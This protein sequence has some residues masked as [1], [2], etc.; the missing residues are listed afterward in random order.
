M[1]DITLA[2]DTDNL[3]LTPNQPLA[4]QL[5]RYRLESLKTNVTTAAPIHVFSAWLSES[6]SK[7]AELPIANDVQLRWL[8]EKALTKSQAKHPNLQA[9]H[10]ATQA[11]S[12]WRYLKRFDVPLDMLKSS[13]IGQEAYFS[14]TVECF[15]DLLSQHKLST[16]EHEI[17]RQCAASEAQSSV[18][19]V[20]ERCYLYAF[21]DEP[22]PLLKQW[23]AHC[24]A[25]VEF[26][27]YANTKS[28]SYLWSGAEQSEELLAAAS[29]AN[30]I[31]NNNPQARVGIVHRDL[32]AD[33][34]RSKRLVRSKLDSA[35]YI[36][37]ALKPPASETGAIQSA[38][39]LLQI[40]RHK[41]K[42]A[43]ARLIIHSPL[44]GNENDYRVRADWDKEVCNTQL[45]ELSFA[46]LRECIK[47]KLSD[48]HADISQRLIAFEDIRRRAPKLQTPEQWATTFSQQLDTLGWPRTSNDKNAETTA[49]IRQ[50]WLDLLRDY[51][52]C[53]AVATEL[54]MGDALSLLQQ[55]C[56]RP[57]TDPGAAHV[58]VRLLDTVEAAADYT[59]LWMIGV[60][61]NQWPA[62]PNPNPL[63]PLGL[64]R[65]FGMPG[66]DRS[67][68]TTVARKLLHRLNSAAQ[69]VVF[70]YSEQSDGVALSAS[71]LLPEG[72]QELVL[73]PETAP[74]ATAPTFDFEFIDTLN[75]P[76]L[77][78]HEHQVRSFA[79]LLQQMAASPFDAFATGR[80]HAR[81]LEETKIGLDARDRGN[82]VHYMMEVIWADLKNQ[83]T[84][85]AMDED[86]RAILCAR[87]AE[88]ALRTWRSSKFASMA[89]ISKAHE[90]LEIQRL[91]SLGMRWLEIE[92]DR[93]PFQVEAIEQDLSAELCGLSFKLR[94]DRIDR[95]EDGSVV[96]LDYKTSKQL[97][98]GKW[99]ESPPSEPQLPLYAIS[100][101]DA[102]DAVAFVQLAPTEARLIGLGNA[103]ENGI[104]PS[105]DWAEQIDSW[106]DSLSALAQA[107][108]DGDAQVH[109]TKSSFGRRDPLIPLHRSLERATLLE[110]K[111]T[112]GN[113]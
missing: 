2:L 111:E 39:G 50:L 40:N 108:A 21:L 57:R 90:Q 80:L 100:L 70:S 99:E 91:A 48:S 68:E 28:S 6:V 42:L 45:R 84:L 79:S 56:D 82:L 89:S 4:Q 24:Y 44:W 19:D 83:A 49:A 11:L 60:D 75:A 74:A 95:L 101:P 36:S 34:L 58:G 63:L 14:E 29:W 13:E 64:Q 35:H 31:L 16:L 10:L 77:K 103:N 30:S 72:L 9:A 53:G 22:P 62:S 55:I 67:I 81:P 105:E 69:D 104:S 106:R 33:R 87:A 98:K 110:I 86:V 23:L 107:Y 76:V 1:E 59:H 93:R 92:A 52:T 73:P 109:E 3:I 17:L 41:L 8:M 43:Q 97:S 47:H 20:S 61:H 102:P 26:V 37:S 71:R 96:L 15:D 85:I 12:A 38:L 94:I 113:S 7:K 78:E 32:R 27:D 66:A 112:G 5:R 18:S 51:A 88:S 65:K 25:S 54:A 46:L